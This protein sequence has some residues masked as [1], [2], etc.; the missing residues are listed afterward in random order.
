MSFQKFLAPAGLALALV[1]TGCTDGN[2]AQDKEVN[3]PSSE[4]G[5]QASWVVSQLN[6]EQ[7]VSVEELESRLSDKVTE[8]M[9]AE[10]LGSVLESDVVPDGPFTLVSFEEKD[11]KA[12]AGLKNE[13]GEVLHMSIAVDSANGKIDGVYFKA[14]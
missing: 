9:S 6:S 1:L 10:E 3:F 13:S 5:N 4:L 14:E 7:G 12:L 11:G 2:G 8:Q